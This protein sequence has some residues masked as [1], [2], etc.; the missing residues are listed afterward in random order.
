MA[1]NLNSSSEKKNEIY[2]ISTINNKINIKK[3]RS[4]IKDLWLL[5]VYIAIFVVLLVLISIFAGFASFNY[6]KFL[7]SKIIVNL[8][9]LL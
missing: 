9:K 5:T 3:N 6:S 1:K 4:A 7:N 2:Q 8:S